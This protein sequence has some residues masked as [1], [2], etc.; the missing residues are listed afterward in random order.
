MP[1]TTQR[2]RLSLDLDPELR[3]RLK[4]VATARDETITA[5]VERLLRQALDEDDTAAWSLMSAPAFA[6]D[7]DSREDAEYDRR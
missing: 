5:Y 2:V 6:R 3:K 7:W 4:L 1:T